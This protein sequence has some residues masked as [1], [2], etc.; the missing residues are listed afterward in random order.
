M[1]TQMI[2]YRLIILV[3]TV[4]VTFFSCNSSELTD[5]VIKEKLS[6]LIKEQLSDSAMR[7]H[8]N[9]T[10]GVWTAVKTFYTTADFEP[11]WINDSALNE[12]GAALLELIGESRKYGLLPQFYAYDSIAAQVP[13]RLIKAEIGLTKAFYLLSTHLHR[14]IIDPHGMKV[15]W[16]KDSLHF[17]HQELLLAV[18]DGEPVKEVLLNLQPE[19]WEYQ[20][21]QKGLED[22]LNT[23]PLDS[24]PF[25]IPPL[26]EDSAK[27]YD[28][29]R[30]ALIG[31]HFLESS[32]AED[33][34]LFIDRLKAFQLKNGLKD[35]A[36]VGKWTGRMLA[37]TNEDRFY[38]AMLSM[39][40]WRWKSDDT[41][42]DRHIWVNI[43][44]YRLKLIDKGQIVRQHRVVV[45]AYGTQTP[46]FHAS[47]KRM[48]TN[49]FWYVP[50][51]IASTEILSGIKKDSSYLSKRGYKIF[52]DGAEVDAGTVDWTAVGATN[53]RYNVRQNGGGGNSLGKIKF[54][55]PNEHAVFIHD[56]P[57]KS[58]FWNDVRAYSHGCV[59]LHEPFELAKSILD[60]DESNVLSDSLEPM[61]QRGVKRVIELNEPIEVYI[62][63]YSAMGD[64]TGAITFYPDIY[65]RDK[66]YIS[67][68]KQN[69]K[70][71]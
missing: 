55:F 48:V 69:L 25:V 11:V 34:S 33:D 64:S 57:S 41:I 12:K 51:S 58:L 23:Y 17:N 30:Q 32:E 54:L 2:K 37:R 14:G 71:E 6:G 44:A 20:Q 43:P 50:Y 46:E 39:E 45:G 65:G 31:H 59:R 28:A 8:Q 70:H 7:Q 26:K 16:F 36:V 68:I 60:L 9:D 5:E 53:F 42:P 40:K 62:E 3:G 49:P 15:D 52:R 4:L 19:F 10:I 67:I 35:D 29:A 13:H 24:A 66:P 56:T 22:F 21:L 47:L 27:C 38:Q 1:E 63:Y 61:I 18:Q